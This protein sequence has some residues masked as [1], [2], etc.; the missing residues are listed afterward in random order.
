MGRRLAPFEVRVPLSALTYKEAGGRKDATLDITIAAVQDNGA[1]S[2]PA[3]E[4]KTVSL[5][6]KQWDK[7]KDRSFIYTGEAKT[8]TGNLRFIASVRDVATNRIGLGSTSVRI[9]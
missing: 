1:R 7:D 4:R 8:R 6:P 9:E 3:T 2:D 5:D